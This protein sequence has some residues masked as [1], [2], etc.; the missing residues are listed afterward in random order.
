MPLRQE[1]AYPQEERYWQDQPF[2]SRLPSRNI[3]Q[4]YRT[5][6]GSD[7]LCF[8]HIRG[9]IPKLMGQ[10]TT[11]SYSIKRSTQPVNV[12]GKN[13]IRGFTK[14]PSFVA[15]SMFF[16]MIDHNIVKEFE[17]L[18]SESV[19]KD[20]RGWRLDEL[21]PFNLIIIAANEY[22]AVSYMT[23]ESVAFTDE[24]GIVS[25][26]DII[27]ETQTSYLARDVIPFDSF[28]P[29]TGS[30]MDDIFTFEDD[31]ISD[32]DYDIFNPDLLSFPENGD[33]L[34]DALEYFKIGYDLMNNQISFKKPGNVVLII[35]PENA[36]KYGLSVY[37]DQNIKNAKINNI[38][39]TLNALL[40]F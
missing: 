34:L 35:S 18:L 24:A 3:S 4:F 26:N 20:R 31:Y 16:S 10:I 23:I 21:P 36:H 40:K 19:P 2:M 12:L 9:F 13:K 17:T 1:I 32:S 30:G 7:A 25:I 38:Q 28:D 6:S 27:T 22:G 14:G 5:F 37:A 29:L 33:Y 15:G 39:N 11:V 8:I